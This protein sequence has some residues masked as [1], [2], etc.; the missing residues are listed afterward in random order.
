SHRPRSRRIDEGPPERGKQEG[1]GREYI[2]RVRLRRLD[3]EPVARVHDEHAECDAASQYFP[4]RSRYCRRPRP[5]RPARANTHREWREEATP[6]DDPRR[7][8]EPDV[9][10]EELEPFGAVGA[11]ESADLETCERKKA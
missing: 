10:L 4:L 9:A 1:D 11:D 5:R 3:D 8:R 6:P 7:G 2:E